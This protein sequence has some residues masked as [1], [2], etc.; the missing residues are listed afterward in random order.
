MSS[1]TQISYKILKQLTSSLWNYIAKNLG[2]TIKLQF[3]NIDTVY[4]VSLAVI[5][6]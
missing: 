5:L 3:I 4:T 1:T 2:S 6:I